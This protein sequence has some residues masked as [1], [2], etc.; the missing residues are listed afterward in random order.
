VAKGPTEYSCRAILLQGAIACTKDF[1]VFF[2]NAKQSNLQE[3]SPAD[4]LF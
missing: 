4:K 3:T 1:C 2:V